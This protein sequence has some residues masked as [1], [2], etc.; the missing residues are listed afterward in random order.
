MEPKGI[1]SDGV[2]PGAETGMCWLREKALR[3]CSLLGTPVLASHWPSRAR[4]KR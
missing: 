1:R 3:I 2:Q 4:G